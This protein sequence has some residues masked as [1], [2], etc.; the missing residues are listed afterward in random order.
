MSRTVILH[1]VDGT[2]PGGPAASLGWAGN[3]EPSE[4]VFHAADVPI[5]LDQAA[6]LG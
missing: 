5:Y 3:F 4:R 6:R 2:V 1:L